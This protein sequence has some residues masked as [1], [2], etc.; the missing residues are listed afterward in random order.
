MDG[1]T[2]QGHVPGA[3]G[4]LAELHALY[5][6]REWGFG[7]SFEAQV[8]AG[9]AEFLQRFDPG[10]DGFWTV[11]RG[12][13]VLGGVAIDGAKAGDEGAHLRW[14]ILSEELRGQGLGGR[15]LGE[16]VDFCR[17]CGHPRIFL[18]TFQG[19]DMAR[20]LYEKMGFRLEEERQG[21]QWGTLVLEQRF[22]LALSGGLLI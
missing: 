20:H 19:L 8:A 5:Y 3:I 7:L 9:L 22:A 14:F 12:G 1:I 15:L 13:R 10:R 17:A 11:S 6:S 16:A 21:R 4:R 2:I 18:W